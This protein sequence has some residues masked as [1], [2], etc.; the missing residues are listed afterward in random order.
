MVE[1]KNITKNFGSLKALDNV[2][3]AF[4][5]GE[6]IGFLGPN[7]SGKTT[8]L[9]IIST[10]LEPDKGTATVEGHDIFK[11]PLEVRKSIGYL[12]ERNI[13]YQHMIVK[14]FLLFVGKARGLSGRYLNSRLEWC[15]DSLKLGEVLRKRNIECSKGF[16]Q[17]ISL[18][19]VLIHD[20]KV[21]LLDEPTSGMDPV[22]IHA[23]RDFLLSLSE[24]RIMILSSHI[25]Q[26]IA[27]IASRVLIIH[28][29]ILRGDL[30]FNEQDNR[31]EKLENLFV[32]SIKES[33]ENTETEIETEEET[34][35]INE[36]EEKTGAEIKDADENP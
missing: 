10:Y 32:N 31:T 27:S 28:K 2:S 22:Q 9:R 36:T 21:I 29:G 35:S 20:P 30:Q 25:M 15:I 3:F 34:N 6:I 23:F 33:D 4:N 7:G 1:V 13:L 17:R 24:D 8:L 26:E 5:K 16:K 12:P 11:N 14:D 18:A 19:A